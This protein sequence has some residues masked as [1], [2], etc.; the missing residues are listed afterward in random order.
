MQ[1]LTPSVFS[2]CHASDH[3]FNM[4]AQCGT[5]TWQ[6]RE[7]F[8]RQCKSLPVCFK[9]WNI[10]Y[11]SML[12]H[13]NIPTL[14]QRRLQ[15]KASMMCQFVHSDSY[16]P[17]DVLLLHPPSNY[18]THNCSYFSIPY[19]RTNPSSHH[20]TFLELTSTCCSSRTKQFSI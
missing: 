7:P 8:W 20:I 11:E 4:H 14:Q 2:N 16:I 10:D 19:A 1:T 3:I 5:L 13:L 12:S 18:D 15:L 6:K 9:N 17:E